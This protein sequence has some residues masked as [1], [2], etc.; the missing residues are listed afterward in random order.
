M[1][2]FLL[3]GFFCQLV[4]GTNKQLVIVTDDIFWK[5][6]RFGGATCQG[7]IELLQLQTDLELSID[8]FN[9]LHCFAQQGEFSLSGMK[10]TILFEQIDKEFYELVSS[11][12]ALQSDMALKTA[13]DVDSKKNN[14]VNYFAT[15]MNGR[16]IMLQ[17]KSVHMFKGWADLSHRLKTDWPMLSSKFKA[18]FACDGCAQDKVK[19][20]MSQIAQNKDRFYERAPTVFGRYAVKN[21]TVTVDEFN[22]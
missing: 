5:I 1:R 17:Y 4:A 3:F 11:W 8:F 18:R 13:V 2:F 6:E 16:N 15:M 12:R 20:L 21:S 10:E 22:G 7:D 14:I 9:R 19:V